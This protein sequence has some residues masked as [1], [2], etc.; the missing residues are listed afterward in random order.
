MWRWSV[1]GFLGRRDCSSRTKTAVLVARAQHSRTIHADFEAVQS[2]FGVGKSLWWCRRRRYEMEVAVE[3]SPWAR[4]LVLLLLT[5]L[6]EVASERVPRIVRKD[7][8]SL[9][10]SS[11]AFECQFH[12]KRHEARCEVR[13]SKPCLTAQSCGDWC[14]LRL[15]AGDGRARLRK[16][17]VDS[18]YLLPPDDLTQA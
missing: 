9:T 11:N 8:A 4:E 17:Q 15:L 18:S 12:G 14:L 3:A 10:R 1:G 7:T 2:F 13:S 6:P 5:Q 16:R